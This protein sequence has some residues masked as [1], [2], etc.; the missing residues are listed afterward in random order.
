MVRTAGTLPRDVLER[1]STGGFAHGRFRLLWG[2]VE[3]LGDAPE[4]D[5]HPQRDHEE[6]EQQQRVHG[7]PYLVGRAR[8]DRP[9]ARFP[10]VA[11]GT[12]PGGRGA[13]R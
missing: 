9:T 10:A 4:P 8:P 3:V 2:D 12:P 6:E 11:P 1:T 5:E 13:R 7:S